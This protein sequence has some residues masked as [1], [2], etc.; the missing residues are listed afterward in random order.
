MNIAI[1]G[2][3]YWGKN[4]Y[5]NLLSSPNINKIYYH[6][7]YENKQFKNFIQNE[8]DLFNEQNNIEAYFVASPTNTHAYY[9]DRI[10]S[11]NKYVCVTKP[12]VKST[13]E[14]KKISKK[15]KNTN[16]IFLDHTYLYH[17]AINK[18][19]KIIEKNIIGKLI[20]FDSERIS[21]GKFYHDQ[22]VIEDLAI[23]DLYILDYLTGGKKPKS[24]QVMKSKNYGNKIYFSNI[25]F[26]YQ[27]D[28]MANIKVNWLSPFK[29]RR[30][31]IGGKKKLLIFDDLS[32]DK[33]IQIYD[34]GLVAIPK[35]KTE[36][37]E[38]RIGDINIPFVNNAETL[39]IMIASFIEF[40][41]KKSKKNIFDHFNHGLRVIETL[42]RIKKI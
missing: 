19:K 18:I 5:R 27:D 6:D 17:P 25:F 16:K 35:S 3:G 8:K 32:S 37:W 38:Y 30:I 26:K 10:L 40:C 21:F 22:N 36:P 31:I 34:K 41:K 1:I 24:I 15:H 14:L 11:K 23:H 29:S 42:D 9:I 4:I 20:Y 7:K 33:K 39:G 28:F 2:L 13:I 12:F